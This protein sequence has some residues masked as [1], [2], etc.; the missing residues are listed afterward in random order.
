MIYNYGLYGHYVFYFRG[1]CMEPVNSNFSSYFFIVINIDLVGLWWIWE[2]FLFFIHYVGSFILVFLYLLVDLKT[3]LEWL[4]IIF[5]CME[6][7]Y[8]HMNRIM[9]FSEEKKGWIMIQ[10]YISG[11]LPLFIKV[12]FSTHSTWPYLT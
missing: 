3:I 4:G 7:I 12:P 9:I 8:F 11:S 10:L 6:C 1:W 2:F 5:P